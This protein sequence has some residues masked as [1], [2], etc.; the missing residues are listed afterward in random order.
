MISEIKE[1][2]CGDFYFI[3]NL[4]HL[5]SYRCHHRFQ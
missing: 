1:L 3:L 2:D 5:S 4:C